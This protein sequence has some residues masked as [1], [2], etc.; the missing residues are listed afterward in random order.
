[1]VDALRALISGGRLASLRLRKD[2]IDALL[3]ANRE[4]I[5]MSIL[6]SSIALIR[7]GTTGIGLAAAQK[8]VAEGASVL[9]PAVM[10]YSFARL[11]W[12]PC[13]HRG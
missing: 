4:K 10:V 6:A 7:G 13:F 11:G 3:F 12:P 1:V 2:A 5:P 8:F 9:S